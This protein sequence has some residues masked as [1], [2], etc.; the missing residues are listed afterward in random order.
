LYSHVKRSVSLSATFFNDDDFL[1]NMYNVAY[2]P[3]SRYVGGV[4]EKYVAVRNVFYQLRYPQKVQFIQPATRRYSHNVYEHS[5][6]RNRELLE[7]YIGMIVRIIDS[8]YMLNRQEGDKGII[9]CASIDFCSLLTERLKEHYTKLSVLRYV[10]SL[11][12]PYDNLMLP[13]LRV[14]THGSAGTAVDV[15]Q[16]TLNLMTQAMRSSPGSLQNLGRL[17]KLPDGRTPLNIFVVCADIPQHVQYHEHRL[18][19]LEHRAASMR[20]DTIGAL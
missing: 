2:P 16:L 10:G 6:M 9:F 5:I 1:L 20:N 8:A 18:S 17:R 13:D 7:N 3:A 12:D 14:S 4:Y 11:D 19:L 15:P